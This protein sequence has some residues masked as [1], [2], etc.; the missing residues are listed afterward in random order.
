MRRAA[1]DRGV[2]RVVSREPGGGGGG[3]AEG[4]GKAGCAK[5]MTRG[6]GKAG[7]RG[8]G[9]GWGVDWSVVAAIPTTL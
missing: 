7:S 2:G 5:I 9:R 8:E 1:G 6:S 4:G 3:C